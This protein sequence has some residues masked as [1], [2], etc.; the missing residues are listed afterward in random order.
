[1]TFPMTNADTVL[2]VLPWSPHLPGGVSVVVTNLVRHAPK[3][4]PLPLV[5]VSDWN[6]RRPSQHD[7]GTPSFRFAVI[8]KSTLIGVLK[9]LPRLTGRLWAL[10]RYMSERRARAVN[11]HYP[12]LDALGVAILKRL[13]CW[14]GRLVLSFH[15][16]D[17]RKPERGL[18]RALWNFLLA[19]ADEITA[20]STSLAQQ[21]EAV[22]G[23]QRARIKVVFNGVDSSLFSRH[24]SALPVQLDLPRWYLA[25]VGSYL[26]RK[27]H[28]VL[29]DAFASIAKK[30][31]DISLVI[32]G[33]DGPERPILRER[34]RQM[35]L[36]QRV[37]LLVDLSPAEVAN[38]LAKSVGCVQAS[39]SEPFGIVII[40]AGAC[41]VPVAAS[42]VG[43]HLELLQSGGF[44]YLFPAGDASACARSIDD[45]LSNAEDAKDKAMRFHTYVV[46]QFSWGACAS[47]YH[48]LWVGSR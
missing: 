28:R 31:P 9:A 10:Q 20:C 36:D 17:V 3:E 26:P 21:I 41:A 4:G 13:G 37:T 24:S 34:M 48:A 23:L 15:G 42:A 19:T 2:L 6:A 16:T 44:G 30:W 47:A 22:L 11:F 39:F 7:D 14:K 12:T 8:G 38:L 32:A 45:L 27:G 5:V 18:D 46:G 33:M 1:M 35:H 43:G 25:S 29:L 40:E